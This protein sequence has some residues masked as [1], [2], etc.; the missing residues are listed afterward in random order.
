MKQQ[1][2][3]SDEKKEAVKDL[4]NLLK[5]NNT[6]LIASIKDIPASQFQEIGKKLRG[7]AE[8]RVPKKSLILRAIDSLKNEKAEKLKEK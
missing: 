4:V 6:I 1:T 3:I 5:N 2:S 7:K 8:V